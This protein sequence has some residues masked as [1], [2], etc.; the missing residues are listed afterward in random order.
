MPR[1]EL[2]QFGDLAP[3]HFEDHPVW[4]SCHSVDYDEP[5]YDDTDDETFRPWTGTLPIDPGQGMYLVRTDF[6][7]GDRSKLRGFL[8]PAQPTEAGPR[9]LGTVQPQVFLPSGER[10]GFWLGMFGN[11]AMASGALS[12]VLGKTAEEIFPIRFAAA[13]DLAAG[14]TTGEIHGFYTIPD[15]KN[16]VIGR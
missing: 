10:I 3:A 5:W 15:G 11:P 7:L 16:V 12:S 9:V 1:P 2:I 14:L 13:P 6:V 8:T 4:V